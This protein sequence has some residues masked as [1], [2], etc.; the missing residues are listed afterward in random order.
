[1]VQMFQKQRNELDPSDWGWEKVDNKYLPFWSELSEP[2]FASWELIK[3][4]SKK[5]CKGLCKYFQQELKYNES[6]FSSGKYT[7]Q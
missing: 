1:M 3:S 6:C 7:I 5:F 4:S 2:S